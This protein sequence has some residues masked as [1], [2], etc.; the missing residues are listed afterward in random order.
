MS[1]RNLCTWEIQRDR[2][3]PASTS[4]WGVA[5]MDGTLEVGFCGWYASR[6]EAL[7]AAAMQWPDVKFDGGLLPVRGAA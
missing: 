7:T 2:K 1:R 3:V 5:L 4:S 6:Q